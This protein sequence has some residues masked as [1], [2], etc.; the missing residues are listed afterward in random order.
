MNSKRS[1]PDLPG[2]GEATQH[3]IPNVVSEV[4]PVAQP[5]ALISAGDRLSIMPNTVHVWAFSLQGSLQCLDWCHRQLSESERTRAES[6]VYDRDRRA[7]VF[8]HGLTRHLLGRC[9]SV[10]AHDLVFTTSPAGKPRLVLADS[11]ISFNLTHAS[12]RALLAVC[13]SREVGVDLEQRRFDIEPLD[14]ARYCFFG[15]ERT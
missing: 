15:S 12:G 6:F 14:I 8:A 2:A 3:V 9:C 1:T 7:Y 13:D 10:P 11:S 5:D 4:V